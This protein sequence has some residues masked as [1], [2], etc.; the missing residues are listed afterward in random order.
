MK[1]EG[2]RIV[3]VRGAKLDARDVVELMIEQP[4][5]KIPDRPDMG[6]IR[7]EVYFMPSTW[8][9]VRWT[10]YTPDKS[11][12]NMTGKFEGRTEY[13]PGTDPPKIIRDDNWLENVVSA[14]Y[15]G[16]KNEIINVQFGA[17]PKDEFKLAAVGVKNI[18]EHD[19]PDE[20]SQPN[21]TR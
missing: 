3:S 4:L 8:A 9:I 7:G 15:Q 6:V 10:L 1:L 13:Q 18:P 5:P 19:I 2:V 16:R 17:I 20:K 14:R 12:K 11:P 21:P